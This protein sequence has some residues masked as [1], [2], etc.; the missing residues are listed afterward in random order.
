[1]M[2]DWTMSD[3]AFTISVQEL[4][5][6]SLAG[7]VAANAQQGAVKDTMLMYQHAPLLLVI[8]AST[9]QITDDVVNARIAAVVYYC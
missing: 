9:K 1:M 4:D 5:L 2:C 8:D 7:H 3:Q 6:P